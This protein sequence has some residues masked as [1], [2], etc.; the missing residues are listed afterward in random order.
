MEYNNV[1]NLSDARRKKQGKPPRSLWDKWLDTPRESWEYEYGPWMWKNSPWAK[2]AEKSDEFAVSLENVCT[3]MA[4][5]GDEE[6]T[7]K[8]AVEEAKY[9][10]STFFEG[11]HFNAE[12]YNSND[13]EI[14]KWAREEVK[15]L[16]AFIRKYEKHVSS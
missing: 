16:R 2:D 14:R 11:G 5:H 3:D 6:P 7:L 13:P 9:V 4:T 1:A 15:H 8:F 12:D 10:L